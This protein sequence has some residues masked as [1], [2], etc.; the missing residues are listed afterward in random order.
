MTGTGK[1]LTTLL[2]AALGAGVT[3]LCRVWLGLPAF[4]GGP[5][6]ERIPL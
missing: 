6:V 2:G 3:M 1:L 4:E 5:V